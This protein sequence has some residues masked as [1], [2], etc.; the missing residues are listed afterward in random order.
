MNASRTTARA[1]FM[2]GRDNGPAMTKVWG[3]E[4]MG[5]VGPLPTGAGQLRAEED[6]ALAHLRLQGRKPRAVG[7]SQVEL[8]GACPLRARLVGTAEIEE[9]VAPFQMQPS[10][11]GGEAVRCFEFRDRQIGT[12]LAHQCLAPQFE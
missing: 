11:V 5:T 2:G 4:N 1:V 7:G 10:P 3:V 12:V 9:R 6:Y 8:R